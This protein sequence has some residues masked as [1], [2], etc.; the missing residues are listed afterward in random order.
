MASNKR[1]EEARKRGWMQMQINVR[2][3]RLE[4]WSFCPMASHKSLKN[5]VLCGMR[6]IPQMGGLRIDSEPM[7]T[8]VG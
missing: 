3:G 8:T 4:G 5:C 7:G 2:L 6:G 1:I